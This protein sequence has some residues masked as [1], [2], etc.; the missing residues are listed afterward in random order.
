MDLAKNK[1]L[2]DLNSALRYF[3][4]AIIGFLFLRG[5]YFILK[6]Y[7]EA[8]SLV[9]DYVVCHKIHTAL[10][11]LNNGQNIKHVIPAIMFLFEAPSEY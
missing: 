7:I 9:H 3:T 8:N 4:W 6:T 10:A 1:G 2:L 5:I 11:T